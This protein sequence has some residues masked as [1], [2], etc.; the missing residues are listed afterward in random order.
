MKIGLL[1][2]QQLLVFLKIEISDYRILWQHY[3]EE[4]QVYLVLY[5]PNFVRLVNL[6]AE[7]NNEYAFNWVFN[8]IE[9]SSFSTVCSDGTYDETKCLTAGWCGL[10]KGMDED[11]AKKLKNYAVFRRY[12]AEVIQEGIN[13]DT[14]DTLIVV[15]IQRCC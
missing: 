7:A 6:I 8:A 13:G 11:N 9:S 5:K 2:V 4:H 1:E 12:L 14:G 15:K 3:L 10:A